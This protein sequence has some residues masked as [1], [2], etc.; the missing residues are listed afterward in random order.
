MKAW[1]NIADN[2]GR[3]AGGV[4]ALLLMLG[5]IPASAQSAGTIL[6][7]VKDA[8][9][10]VVPGA[11]VTITNIETGLSRTVPS[12]A[13]GAFRAPAL[14]VGR[15]NLRI[16]KTGFSTEVQRGLILE[17]EQEL[18]VNAS[19][20]IGAT[21]QEVTVSGEAPLVNTTS[22]A[23]GSMVNEQKM[24]DLPLN[25][26]NYVDLTMIQ[27]GVAKQTIARTGGGTNAGTS[28]SANGAP[29]RSNNFTIDGTSMDE[30]EGRLDLLD[31]WNFSRY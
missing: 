7:V 29:V 12:S 30:C 8:S 22:S 14:P 26:R 11:T 2:N 17:V 10:A 9:G 24:S 6:G 27:P 3:L 15:Y 5:A 25:G 18:V 1:K 13:D 23:L 21:T 19:L 4:I 20:Q 28:F 31:R 16:E